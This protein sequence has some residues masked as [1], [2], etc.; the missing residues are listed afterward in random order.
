MCDPNHSTRRTSQLGWRFA[1]SLSISLR[2]TGLSI[3]DQSTANLSRLVS[4]KSVTL[5]CTGQESYGRL[6]CKVL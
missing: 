3:G 6:V 4:G 2:P 1:R 5:Y